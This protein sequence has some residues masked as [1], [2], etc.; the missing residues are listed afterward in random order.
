[1]VMKAKGPASCLPA[2]KAGR[3]GFTL[4]ELLVVIAV[5]AVLAAGTFAIINPLKRI[6]QAKDATVKSDVGQLVRLVQANYTTNQKY[7]SSLTELE[8]SG[9]IKKLPTPPGGGSYGY[10]ISTTCVVNNCEAALWG[11]LNDVSTTTYHCWDS[12]NNTFKN[13]TA[14]PTAA[15]PTCP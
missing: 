1:M 6:N 2:G 15:S 11:P 12:T 8:T 4:I 10:I 14:L 13:S 3:G 5:I 9:E 7:P